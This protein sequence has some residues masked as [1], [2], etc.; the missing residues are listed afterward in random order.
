VRWMLSLYAKA[1]S[2]GSTG[3]ASCFG[4]TYWS[5]LLSGDSDN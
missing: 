1:D 3:V 2:T 5:G 4:E